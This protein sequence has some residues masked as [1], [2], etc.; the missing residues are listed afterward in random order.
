VRLFAAVYPPASEVARL[1]SAVREAGLPADRLRPVPPSQ[2]HLTLAF[3]G[4]VPDTRVDA[5]TG[6]LAR[7]AA[8]TPPL[9]LRLHGA[10]AFGPVTRARQ[11]WV[12]VD[13]DL[14]ELTRLAD[15]CAAAG[16]REGQRME[17]RRFRPHL[18]L[19][20]ARRST[21]DATT[22]IEALS[23]YGGKPFTVSG[24]HLV[25]STLGSRV[26]HETIAAHPLAHH[27]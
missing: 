24:L 12:G 18:T 9:H 4:E 8:S 17:Q 1:E 22:L 19:G 5:L 11:V 20:R 21:L 3:Y 23:T 7:A 27:A 2:W 16:R 26:T 25:R 15:R 14:P 6:R 10:G 13:G